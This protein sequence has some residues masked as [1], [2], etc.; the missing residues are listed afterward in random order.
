M[1][2]LKQ[3]IADALRRYPRI[4]SAEF[5]AL[6][7]EFAVSESYLRKLLR[8]SGQP[9]APAVEGVRQDNFDHLER[10][11]LA[12]SPEH[13]PLVL[14][15]KQHARL[16]TRSPRV[17]RRIKGEMIR[18][19]DVWLSDPA[20][21]PAWVALRRRTPDFAAMARTESTPP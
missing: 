19:M 17:D 1:A 8:Q 13:R 9:L 6:R 12:L 16:A 7:H 11:L 10:T 15:A 3:R 21:F 18:W 20:L 2:S 5:A 4:D 14:A